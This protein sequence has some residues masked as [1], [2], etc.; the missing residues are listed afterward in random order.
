MRP[1]LPPNPTNI[2]VITLDE[3]WGGSESFCRLLAQEAVLAI[4][5]GPDS[6]R[7][8]TYH[9]IDRIAVDRA[10]EALGRITQR[11][12]SRQK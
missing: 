12:E 4:P 6:V 11:L 1:V 9:N 10:L 5:F 2:V 3:I 7:F 8:V